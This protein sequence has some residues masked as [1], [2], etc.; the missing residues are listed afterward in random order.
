MEKVKR[1][2]IFGLLWVLLVYPLT[3]Y[4]QNLTVNYQGVTIEQVII[5]LKQKTDYNFVYQKR[6]LEGKKLVTLSFTNVPMTY[7][8]DRLL[9]EEGLDYE[10]VKQNVIIREADKENFKRVVSGKVVGEDGVPMPGVNIRIKNTHTGMATD[11]NGEFSIVV[12]SKAPILVFSFVGMLDKEVRISRET[13]IPLE[14][15]MISDIALMEEVIVTG[16]QNI[17]R[18]HATGA[19]QKVSSKE[20]GNRYSTDIVSN[21]EGRI[22][23]LVGYKNGLNGEGESTLS[24][25][26]V[27]S[28]QAKTNPLV[29]VDGLP[30]EGSI[31]TVN[32]YDIENITVLKDAS[33][34][35]I[36]GARASNGVIVITT[37]RALSEK[38]DIDVS[39]DLSLSEKQ[40]YDNYKWCTPS[41]LIKLE[42]YNFKY[43]TEDPEG[44]ETLKNEYDSRRNLMSPIMQLMMD[45]YTG[46]I[47]DAAYKE[48]I[49]KWKKNNYRKEWQE[50]MLRRQL[51]Q[52]YNVALRTKG[53]YLNSSIVLNYKGDNT[54]MS[55]QD[56]H[57]LTMSYKGDLDVS[58]YLDF[59]FGLNLMK[60]Y[61]KMHADM[62]GYKGMHAFQPYLSMYNEDGSRAVMRAS[63]DLS[64]P[65]LTDSSLGLKSEE[66]NLLD[67]V[68]RNF[69]KT[70]RTN[71]RTFLHAT[72]KV[73]PVLNVG[74]N[75]Q[76]E[77]ISYKSEE[78]YEKDSY[79]M[80]HLYN[81][82]TSDGVH[83]IP[84]GGLLKVNNSD[85][86]YY[87]FRTQINYNQ[88]LSEKH[89]IEAI[90]GFEYREAKDR[91][92]VSML[93]GYDDQSQTNTTHLLD[94]DAIRNLTST[95]LGTNYSPLEVSDLINYGTTETLHRF[96]SLYFNA[97]Y[98]YDSRYS[99]S[100]SYRLDK[101]DLFGADPKYRGRPLWSAGA[102]WNINNE[103]FMEKMDWI[104][105][106]KLRVSYGLTGNIDSSVSSFLTASININSITGDKMATLNTPPND[107]L[108]WEKTE[109]WNLGVDFALFSNRL[110]GSLDWYRKY[111]S[112][113]LATTDLDPTSGWNSLTIN[114]GEALNTGVELMLNGSILS[115][116]DRNK[117]GIHATLA[118]A[119]NKN[120]VKK[121]DHAAPDGYTSLGTLHEGRPVN[122]LFSYRFA[123]YTNDE[124]GNQ[125]VTWKKADGTIESVSVMQE[126]FTPEDI[127]FSGGLDPKYTASFTPEFTYQG[128]T[129]SA[130]FSYYGGHYMR[131]RV[132]DYTNE[133]S[134]LGYGNLEISAV[135]RSYLNYWESGDK[136]AYLA[137][138]YAANAMN[139][140]A[141][142]YSDQNV[143]PADFMKVRTIVLGYDFPE[144]VCKKIGVGAARLRFQ[145]NNVATWVR[146]K[147][148][149][150][151]EANDPYSGSTLDKTPRSYTV[152]L[153]IN[154]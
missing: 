50:V 144:N 84:E 79:D 102:S 130:M 86:K 137:N 78:F 48:Q 42:E 70:N 37:K 36:Y 96:Y 35:S 113:L 122:S 104:N 75:F 118:F 38:L 56:S 148:N 20:L 28:F 41:Q 132:D 21:L 45:R 108:R 68:D 136:N 129:L 133:G 59:S 72:F 61:S 135:P 24:I 53:K 22:P 74:A 47:G 107:Q 119:Y 80:R 151:P 60:E 147:L 153:N 25:R 106:L 73:L 2:L 69:T 55:E 3:G 127:V 128:F 43:V 11:I 124:N 13:K 141:P 23:G 58:K 66:F 123:G 29:V 142:T 109:S 26:G 10:I 87:T 146:N 16:Y 1:S 83:Y 100:F 49:E 120:E 31:E 140:I 116:K 34:A 91:T 115:A 5:D 77:D 8:L 139:L 19:Y 95:D 44:Y 4:S 27:G 97:N 149:V 111:S 63:V 145:V 9:L 62:F 134:Y 17:K 98:T 92:I 93:F 99:A 114:N 32:P 103:A 154:F 85:G 76:Y 15:R 39:V 14:I 40:N 54:G 65:S 94:F 121:V 6:I 112:D 67:E 125:Q 64:E 126:T 52:Q 7:I 152:S 12:D 105:A 18:E 33:A 82:F 101:T 89:A 90:A 138:G 88:V 117:L 150:D 57:A 143:V 46:S 71:L 131:T 81:L 110:N 30:I 51:L